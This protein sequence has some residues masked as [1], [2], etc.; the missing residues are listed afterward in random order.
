[1]GALGGAGEVATAILFLELVGVD[2]IETGS[3]EQLRRSIIWMDPRAALRG[4]VCLS[5]RN[6]C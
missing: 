6:F 1:M 2:C 3:R 5:I 4:I